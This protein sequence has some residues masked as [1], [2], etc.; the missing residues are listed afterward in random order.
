MEEARGVHFFRALLAEGGT[1][2][3]SGLLT[4]CTPFNILELPLQ[5]SGL[6]AW[7]L[8]GKGEES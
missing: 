1:T 3:S 5:Q 2:N 6:A 8:R 7:T 4:I